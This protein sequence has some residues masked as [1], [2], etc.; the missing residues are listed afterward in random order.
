MATLFPEKMKMQASGSMTLESIAAK[1]AYFTLQVQQIHWETTSHAEHSALNF[2]DE[3]FD[4]RDD[5]MEKLMGYMGRRPKGYKVDPILEGQSGM[6][7]VTEV[8][9]FAYALYEWAGANHYCDV[10]NMAQDLSGRAAKT[11]YLLTQS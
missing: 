10:E 9:D 1:L 2:Y 5:V 11:L 3:I 8:K 6:E 7:Y 4:F